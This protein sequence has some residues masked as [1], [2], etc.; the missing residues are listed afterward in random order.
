MEGQNQKEYNSKKNEHQI[1]IDDQN[2][3]CLCGSKLVF[4]HKIDYMTLD[5]REDADCQSC[6]IR[7]KTRSHRLQ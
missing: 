4:K 3:C 1:A 2:H 5:V 7:L 6:G